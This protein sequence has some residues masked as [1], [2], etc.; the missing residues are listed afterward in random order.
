[1]R[2]RRLLLSSLG[3]AAAAASACVRPRPRQE[4]AASP[5]DAAQLERWDAEARS[6][7]A[8]AAGALR[9]FDALAAYQLTA[10]P[11]S[12]LRSVRELEWDPPT[13]SEWTD[14]SQAASDV[15]TRSMALQGA[16]ATSTPDPA[17]WRERRRL[18]AAT[19]SLFDMAEA[20]IEYRGAAEALPPESDGGEAS[21][22]LQRAWNRWEASAAYWNVT[23]SEPIACA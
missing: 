18:A 10:A 17:L 6:L 2:R 12:S 5:T 7:L 21:R 3:I 20:M 4:P 15:R 14:A 9:T 13:T 23:R 1:M 11:K 8:R 19:R 22:S 16:V